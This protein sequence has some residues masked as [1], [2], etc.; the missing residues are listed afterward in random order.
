MLISQG[1]HKKDAYLDM[2]IAGSIDGVQVDIVHLSEDLLSGPDGVQFVFDGQHISTT[3]RRLFR[4]AAPVSG[5]LLVSHARAG[6]KSVS[7]GN[8]RRNSRSRG[9]KCWDDVSQVLADNCWETG[10]LH[11]I[12]LQ[13]CRLSSRCYQFGSPGGE[14]Q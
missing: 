2:N 6:V 4:F 3:E 11:R 12:G 7:G 1:R 9:T 8:R 10:A 13:L 5:F 14:N